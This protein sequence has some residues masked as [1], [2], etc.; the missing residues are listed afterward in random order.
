V[1]HYQPILDVA[2]GAVRAVEALVRWEHPTRGLL[3]PAEFLAV[4]DDIGLDEELG[5]IVLDLVGRDMPELT[6]LAPDLYVAINASASQLTTP[7]FTDQVI[8]TLARHGVVPR[9]VC[10]E[11]SERAI[12]DRP[13]GAASLPI[14]EALQALGK[15]G[16]RIAVDDF[17]TGYSSLSHLITFPIDV[18]KIDRMFVAGIDTDKDRHSVV[19]AVI[20]MANAMGLDS[21]AEGIEHAYQLDMLRRLGCRLGQGYLLG[22]PMPLDLLLTRFPGYPRP[23]NPAPTITVATSRT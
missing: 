10:I 6:T 17:G 16:L 22:R 1:V 12:L 20:G 8:S 2:D 3:A 15:Q 11:I 9:Q 21:V 4:V 19:A 18:L 13:R 7:G 14:V 23:T 5:E